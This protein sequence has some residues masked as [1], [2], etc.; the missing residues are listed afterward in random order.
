MLNYNDANVSESFCHFL[1][2]VAATVPVQRIWLDTQENKE[3]SQ[4]Q[5]SSSIDKKELE[6]MMKCILRSMVEK[7]GYSLEVARN[8]LEKLEP[9]NLYPDLIEKINI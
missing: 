1:K 7:K 9:F 2:L 3:V 6:N 8:H 4:K 5:L